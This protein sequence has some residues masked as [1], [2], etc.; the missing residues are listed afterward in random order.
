[1][2]NLRK[3]RTKKKISQQKLA[4]MVGLNQP[5]IFQYEKG[6]LEPDQATLAKLADCL[7]TTSDYLI[8]RTDYSGPPPNEEDLMFLDA[9]RKAP[10]K[11]RKAF[12]MILSTYQKD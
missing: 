4:E 9:L 12:L 7:E 5:S 11:V 10:P 6:R 8:G 3:L 1:M 2:E